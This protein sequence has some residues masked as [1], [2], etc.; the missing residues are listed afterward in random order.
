MSAQPS[1]GSLLNVVKQVEGEITFNTLMELRMM[2]D[3]ETNYPCASANS[4]Y[5]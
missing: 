2:W 4:G 5:V 1:A 3:K